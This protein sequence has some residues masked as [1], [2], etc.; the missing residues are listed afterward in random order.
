MY[1]FPNI[2]SVHCSTSGSN[3]CFLTCIQVSQE[4]GKVVWYSHLFKNFP[5]FVVIHTVKGF[6]IASEAEVDVF[7][8]F[9]FFFCDLMVLGDLISDSSAFSKSSLYIWK[10][11]VQVLSKPSLMNFEHTL[12]ACEMSAVV[13]YFEH[14]LPLPFFG[15][16]TK[17]DLFQSCGQG[18]VLQ[19]CWHVECSTLTASSFRIWTSSPGIPSPPVALFIVML[20]KAQLDVWL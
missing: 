2:E 15:I 13:W 5:Q 4:S 9:P 12:L 6:R 7:L 10:F 14:S 20:T 8:E 17:T 11:L 3:C 16:G 19:I 18:W 1:S